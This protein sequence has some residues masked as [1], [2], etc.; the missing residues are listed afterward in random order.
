MDAAIVY[1]YIAG[2][3]LVVAVIYAILIRF[4]AGPIVWISTFGIGVGI[5]AGALFLQKFH[6]T[7]FVDN[8]NKDE[9][10]TS[11]KAL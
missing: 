3:V 1:A 2:T 11:A 9:N 8:P 5:L 7:N 10:S 6:T 4:F